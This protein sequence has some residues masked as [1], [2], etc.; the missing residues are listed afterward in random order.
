[1]Y[2]VSK[3]ARFWFLMI[4]LHEA[5]PLLFGMIVLQNIWMMGLFLLY[6]VQFSWALVLYLNM[7]TRML[8]EE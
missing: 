3:K 7:P 8:F 2:S 5:I 4:T 6:L 1:M